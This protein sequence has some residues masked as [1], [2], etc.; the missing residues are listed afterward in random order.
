MTVGFIRGIAVVAVESDD[1]CVQCHFSPLCS[2]TYKEEKAA[3]FKSCLEGHHY[4]QAIATTIEQ[5][6]EK[7]AER[8]HAELS[9]LDQT[10]HSAVLR[11]LQSKL[12]QR[13]TAAI[14]KPK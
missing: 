6:A 7:I 8:I 5:Q 2:I 11:I 13:R 3:G 4:E 10:K 1:L 14:F 12:G 9:M